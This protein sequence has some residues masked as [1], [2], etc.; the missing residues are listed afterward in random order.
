MLFITLALWIALL[1]VEDAN[2]TH[3]RYSVVTWKRIAKNGTSSWKDSYY[4]EFR[5][6]CGWNKNFP[7]APFP[8]M[9]SQPA[10]TPFA[11]DDITFGQVVCNCMIFCSYCH[12]PS[13][14]FDFIFVI[15]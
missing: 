15:V 13:P 2:G 14:N 4:Y 7:V 11:Y 10:G 1:C 6:I 12:T 9:R 8:S 5:V 3:F